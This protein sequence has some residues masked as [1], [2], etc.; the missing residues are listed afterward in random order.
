MNRPTRLVA[1]VLLLCAHAPCADELRG[2]WVDAFHD[3]IKTPAQTAQLV[4]DAR[5]GNFNALFVQV[6]KRGDAYYQSTLEP[7]A[8]DI[9]PAGYDPMPLR[10]QK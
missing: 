10:I 7:K 1:L 6:R 3:G 2:L 9:S 8:T 4:A 5:A